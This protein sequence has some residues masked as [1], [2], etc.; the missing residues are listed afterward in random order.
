MV[1]GQQ[2]HPAH[3][4]VVEV[5]HAPHGRVSGPLQHHYI[6]LVKNVLCGQEIYRGEFCAGASVTPAAPRCYP[7]FLSC[8]LLIAQNSSFLLDQWRPHR[9]SS[10]GK[11]CSK[12]FWKKKRPPR[13]HDPCTTKKEFIHDAAE[14]N[15]ACESLMHTAVAFSLPEMRHER[16]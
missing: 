2:I 8:V 9:V 12:R 7:C 14:S 16:L 10:T 13:T 4:R 3:L 11:G 6:A 5:D 15:V 1:R